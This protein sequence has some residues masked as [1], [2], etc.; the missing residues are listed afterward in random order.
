M[1]GFPNLTILTTP[2]MPSNHIIESIRP[3]TKLIPLLVLLAG[4]SPQAEVRTGV[5][6]W[7]PYEQWVKEPP[8]LVYVAALDGDS[9]NL[10]SR[11]VQLAEAVLTPESPSDSTDA[12]SN[13]RAR[14]PGPVRVAQAETEQ[15]LMQTYSRSWNGIT[16]SNLDSVITQLERKS[17][18]DLEK[19]TGRGRQISANRGYVQKWPSL[20]ALARNVQAQMN[21]PSARDLALADWAAFQSNELPGLVRTIQ[22]GKIKEIA[23]SKDGAFAME[24]NGEILIRFQAGSAELYYPLTGSHRFRLSTDQPASP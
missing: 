7:S 15:N 9:L 3:I 24:E 1:G 20:L 18:R 22:Q 21:R 19:Y 11:S 4:C 10:L 5:L 16:A 2:L 23:L 12:I 6:D 14:A 13:L 8:R 17:Q